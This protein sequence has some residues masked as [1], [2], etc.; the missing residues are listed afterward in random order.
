M[1]RIVKLT[2]RMLQARIKYANEER[3]VIFS[4]P[5][6]CLHFLRMRVFINEWQYEN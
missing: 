4:G 2:K 5:G 3:S 6:Q 1:Q